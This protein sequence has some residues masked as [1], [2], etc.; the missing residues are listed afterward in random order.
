[1]LFALPMF[2][3]QAASARYTYKPFTMVAAHYSNS[4]LW[5]AHYG[6]NTPGTAYYSDSTTWAKG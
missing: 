5:I 3:G 4:T 2:Y 6:N 1:M